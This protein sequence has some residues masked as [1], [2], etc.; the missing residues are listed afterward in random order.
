MFYKTNLLYD[1]FLYLFFGFFFKV[2]GTDLLYCLR[3]VLS[4]Q[5]VM[6]T[7]NPKTSFK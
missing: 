6:F 2:E 4:T 3:K 7:L 1:I 5:Q